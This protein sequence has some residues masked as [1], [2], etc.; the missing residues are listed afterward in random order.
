MA[1]VV[2]PRQLP[3]LLQLADPRKIL[4]GSDAPYTPVKLIQ[5]FSDQL[6]NTDLLTATFKKD[7][8][9]HNGLPLLEKIGWVPAARTDG[10]ALSKED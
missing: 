3:L 2:L 9:Y 5:T 6:E 4:Y 10:S 8:F 1:G 7:L